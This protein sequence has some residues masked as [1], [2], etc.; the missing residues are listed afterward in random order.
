[1]TLDIDL[2]ASFLLDDSCSP[3]IQGNLRSSPPPTGSSVQDLKSVKV[4]ENL[5]SPSRSREKPPSEP[6]NRDKTVRRRPRRSSTPR[7][8]KRSSRS[9]SHCLTKSSSSRALHSLS[10]NNS[11]GLNRP[12]S[13]TQP[14]SMNPLGLHPPSEWRSHSIMSPSKGSLRLA[15]G[16]KRVSL[17]RGLIPVTDETTQKVTEM[18]AATSAL[19]PL[20]KLRSPAELDTSRSVPSKML[21]MMTEIWDRLQLKA[22]ND[23]DSVAHA[24]TLAEVS[25]IRPSK[26]MLPS[27]ITLKS[28]ERS[29]STKEIRK[30]EGENLKH[31]KVQRITGGRLTGKGSSHAKNTI[32]S[33][34]EKDRGLNTFPLGVLANRAPSRDKRPDRLL[35]MIGAACYDFFHVE[36]HVDSDLDEGVLQATPLG[37]ST[38]RVSPRGKSSICSEGTLTAFAMRT[39]PSPTFSEEKL[40]ALVPPSSR[41]CVMPFSPP[42]RRS[43]CAAAGAAVEHDVRPE[44]GTGQPKRFKKHPSPSKEALE[45]LEIALQKVTHMNVAEAF[46]DKLDELSTSLPATC[47]SLCPRDPNRLMVSHTGA[48]LPVKRGG[49]NEGRTGNSSSEDLQL[50]HSTSIRHCP[51]PA[52]MPRWRPLGPGAD[53]TDEL[54]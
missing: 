11:S 41:A 44:Y 25:P 30:N 43:D 12:L 17:A 54:L 18:L 39:V 10:S 48:P 40:I 21:N 3:P 50:R 27:S 8:E 51:R 47:R 26:A 20:S 45:D 22:P 14:P 34:E 36:E 16:S 15:N 9:S 33:R 19:K 53:D 7:I 42:K 23:A 6:D 2:L 31:H 28:I 13:M 5:G 52:A 37:S 1:M 35:S 29:I 4:D 32:R 24:S 46:V 38:P 49:K